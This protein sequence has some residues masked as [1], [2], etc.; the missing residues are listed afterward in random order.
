MPAIDDRLR[1]E[2]A[3]I[4][5]A[6]E[7]GIRERYSRLT[8]A[9][10]RLR[11]AMLYSL[12]AGGKRL[13]PALVL[14]S[15]ELCGG[16]LHAAMPAAIAIESVHTFSLIHDDLPPIDNDDLR[17]G[18][19]TNHRVFGEATAILAGDALL[20][21]AFELLATEVE[22]ADRCKRMIA[23]LANAAGAAGMIGG[24]ADDIDGESLPSSRALV[25]RIHRAKTARLIQSACRLGAMSADDSEA[26]LNRLSEYGLNLGLAFQIADDLLDETGS[27]ELAGKR[28][29]KDLAAGKQTY[30]RAIG[31]EASRQLAQE[32]VERAIAAIRP[33][34][35]R[36][37]RLIDL[38]KYVVE[39]SS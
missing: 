36:A 22:P 34:G 18:L 33:F 15:C 17:R 20:A 13:R 30:P 25:H 24:E 4:A 2:L 10:D 32:S 14:W 11:E 3:E 6:V 8:D 23:E 7:R 37:D 38:A 9:P 29:G 35:T 39:R 26:N 27:S 5:V 31:L 1:P 28:L 19:P 12:M 21:W 16:L